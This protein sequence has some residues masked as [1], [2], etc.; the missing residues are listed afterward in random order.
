MP[1]VKKLK[2]DSIGSW[3]IIKHEIIRKYA[4]AY[5]EVLSTRRAPELYHVYIDAFAGPG[6]HRCKDTG[7]FVAGSPQIVLNIIPPF[8]EYYF[9]D[10]DS[11][12]VNELLMLT[13]QRPEAQVYY[14]DCNDILINEIFPQVNF[15]DYKRGLCL[16]DPYG[17]HLKWDVIQMAGQMKSI[18]MFLNFPI[19]DINRNVLWRKPDGVLAIN[20]KRMGEYWGDKSWVEKAYSTQSNL[21][22]ETVK[23]K[24]SNETI[25]SAFQDRLHDVAGFK[26][27][28]RPLPMHNSRRAIVYYLLFASQKPVALDIINSIFEKYLSGRY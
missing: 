25:V 15:A 6:K 3:S 13:A 20:I 16:L 10:I 4:K 8:R 5:S 27:V 7:D 22:G 23:I 21:F 18:D 28:S 11:A 9:I 2:Y 1:A 24:Q 17:L 12:K 19:A 14:G 26:H